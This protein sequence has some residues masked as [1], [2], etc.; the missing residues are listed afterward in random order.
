M[1][2]GESEETDHDDVE[3]MMNKPIVPG[4]PS[5]ENVLFVLLGVLSMIGVIIHLIR[6]FT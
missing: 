1:N 4:T 5:F 2:S 6:L 3:R